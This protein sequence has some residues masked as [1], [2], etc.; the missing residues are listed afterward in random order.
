MC[1]MSNSVTGQTETESLSLDVSDAALERVATLAN[2]QH[3]I[4]FGICTDWYTC[5][6]PLSPAEWQAASHR[7]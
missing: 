6:W 1:V 7:T 3:G 2:G 5:S 4:T